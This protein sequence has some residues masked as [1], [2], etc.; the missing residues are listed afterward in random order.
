MGD[1]AGMGADL[2]ESY[3]NSIIAAMAIGLV[4]YGDT[5][6]STLLLASSA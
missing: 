5:G 1:I 6:S 2:F 3:V 4:A